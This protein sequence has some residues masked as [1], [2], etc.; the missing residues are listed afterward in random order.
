MSISKEVVIDKIEIIENGTVQVR[1][2][3]KLVEDGN[4]VG[5]SSHRHVIVPGADYSQEDPKVR[6]VC[7][8]THTRDT[9]AA[10]QTA[11]KRAAARNIIEGV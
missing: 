10:Y 1:T 9:I 11:L 6:E 3:T 7:A 4:I 8:V 5:V 2:T